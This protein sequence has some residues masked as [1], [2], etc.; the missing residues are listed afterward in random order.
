[1]HI[2]RTGAMVKKMFL[3]AGA[4]PPLLSLFLQTCCPPTGHPSSAG[5]MASSLLAPSFWMST[6]T[7]SFWEGKT[8]YI[9]S[10][11]VLSA[12]NPKR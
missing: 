12:V 11:W 10:C 5:I 2:N 7:G 3:V 1:M 4:H 9:L 8:F 6:V